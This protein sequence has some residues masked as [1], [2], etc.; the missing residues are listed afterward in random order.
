MAI[1]PAI[2]GTDGSG[3]GAEIN[4]TEIVQK[5]KSLT[6]PNK[7]PVSVIENAV[8]SV[9]SKTGAVTITTDSI[10]AQPASEQLSSLA[11]ATFT[12]EGMLWLNSDGSF[13]TFTPTNYTQRLMQ[14]GS[15]ES[16]RAMLNLGSFAMLDVGEDGKIP[17]DMLSEDLSEI[18][19]TGSYQDLTDKPEI[20]VVE[21][22]VD[23]V[24]GKTGDV[25]IA[26]KDIGAAN[27]EHFH[28]LEDINGLQTSLD[29]KMDKTGTISYSSITGTPAL[30]AVATTG[31]YA[32]LINKPVLFSGDYSDLNN[33]PQLFDGTWISLTGKPNFS[34]VATSGN[35]NDLVNKPTLFDGTW[36]SLTGKPTFATVAT[37]GS[38]V[39]LLNKPTIPTSTSQ[40]S[41]GTNLYFTEARAAA[42]MSTAGF[43]KAETLRGTTNATGVYQVTFANTYSTPPHVNPVIINGTP[44]MMLTL[45]NITTTGC[46]VTVVQR[47]AV[48][49]LGLEVLLAATTPVSG[50][51]VDVFVLPK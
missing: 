2:I 36:V 6:S 9:N 8:T 39:D 43:R 48:T 37:S 29:S 31:S 14:L 16:Y 5:L 18:A 23:S 15:A 1:T 11:N 51:V 17:V 38:Y 25:V 19:Y 50:A 4:G 45:T 46:T 49:L 30:S 44:A 40:I 13:D 21:Y 7:L 10:G 42:A 24:N 12:D 47:A 26:A 32:D 34:T 41:E 3:S 27:S 35:Y 22:P 28:N 20:P 33:K